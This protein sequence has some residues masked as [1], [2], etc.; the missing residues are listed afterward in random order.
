MPVSGERT[1]SFSIPVSGESAR[2]S[3]GCLFFLERKKKEK[4]E[5]GHPCSTLHFQFLSKEVFAVSVWRLS[6][7]MT[8][9][10]QVLRLFIKEEEHQDGFKLSPLK[11]FGP[12]KLRLFH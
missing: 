9:N 3:S 10:F 2:R 7:L 8:S 12:E 4:K 1:E 6:T 11:G 5:L